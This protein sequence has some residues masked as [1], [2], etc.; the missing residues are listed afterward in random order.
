MSATAAAPTTDWTALADLPLRVDGYAL[1]A[2]DRRVTED[3]TRPTTVVH[4][5]GEGTEGV[6]EDTTYAPPDQHGFRAAGA[7]L[8]LAGDWTLRSF[9]AHLDGLDLFPPGPRSQASARS[10]A[11]PSRARRW[12]SRCASAACRSPRR[13]AARRGR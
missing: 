10:G 6:G 13:S 3:Y 12:T 4:L 2:L 9:S 8:P 1:E 7:V 5:R 11:G